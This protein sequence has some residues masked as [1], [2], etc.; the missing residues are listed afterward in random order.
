MLGTTIKYSDN[1]QEDEEDLV[2]D[3]SADRVLPARGDTQ[4]MKPNLMNS[5]AEKIDFNGTRARGNM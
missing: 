5:Q 2:S 3:D 4:M 1:I